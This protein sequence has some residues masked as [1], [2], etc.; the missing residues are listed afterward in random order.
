MSKKKKL[1][2]E[3]ALFAAFAAVDH[4]PLLAQLG[5]EMSEEYLRHALTHRSFANENGHLPNNE[6]LEFLGDAVL[7]L[8]VASKL[9]T[10]YPSRPES[11]ISKMRA[12]I[13]S[14]Y[15]LSDIA[16]EIELGKHILLGKG[17]QST[18]G[19]DKDSILADT[20]EAIFGAIYLQFGF[21]TAREVILRLFAKKIENASIS[22][23]HLDWKTTLQEL[24]ADLHASM[25][26][27]TATSTGPEHDQTFSAVATVAGVS[28]G[29]GV[30][31]NKKLAEQE[32]AQQ[33]FHTLRETPLLVQGTADKE[34]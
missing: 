14:R 7:G 24:C 13:V 26:V 29:Q 27:Y 32:A 3:E 2:G 21:E 25:P 22:G 8:S 20:T 15:G 9:Y 19:R 1:T 34:R 12:S 30:G 17:E 11:D 4:A 31:H 18:G 10:V 28:V 23:R 33:A 5:V 16:R 6:R